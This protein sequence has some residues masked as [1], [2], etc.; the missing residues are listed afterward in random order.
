MLYPFCHRYSKKEK[1]IKMKK[2][3]TYVNLTVAAGQKVQGMTPVY[4][5]CRLP[6]TVINGA[7]EGETLLITAGIHGGEYPCIEAAT[8]LAKKINPADVKGQII[9]INCVNM[10]GF[11]DRVSY[12]SPLDGKNLNRLFPGDESGT[13]GDRLAY[14]ITENYQKR[15]DYYLDL[16]GGDI[17]EKLP[18]YVYRPGVGENI[19]A[20]DKAYQMAKYINAE[21]MVKSKSTTG[22]Y[23]SRA[24]LGIPSLLIE[25]GCQGVWDQQQVDDYIYDVCN[26]MK[27]LGILEGQPVLPAVPAAEMTDVIY[28]DSDTTGM[29]HSL[30]D[31]REKVY[32]GQKIGYITDIFGNVIKE[33]FAQFDATILYIATSLAI[34]EGTAIITYGK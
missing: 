31:I 4:D 23:N 30:A 19:S 28:L 25:R 1:D 10:A 33:Y 11:Y 8:Q 32:R 14:F 27:Y 3:I 16:H 9:I 6:V 18:P 12:I 21:F 5:V 24:I 26:V 34:T 15:A 7:H 17:H 22:A 29:W 2:E 20:L 13:A